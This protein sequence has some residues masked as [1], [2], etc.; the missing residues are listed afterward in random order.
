MP[1]A[2]WS[3][4]LALVIWLDPMALSAIPIKRDAMRALIDLAQ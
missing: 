1:H 4:V 3:S 2:V